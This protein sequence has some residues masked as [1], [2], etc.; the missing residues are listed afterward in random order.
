[1]G[2]VRVRVREGG[3]CEGEGGWMCICAC[4]LIPCSVNGSCW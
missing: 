2:C 1:M 4:V 3:M